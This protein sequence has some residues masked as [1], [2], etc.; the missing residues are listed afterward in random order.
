[1]G[2]P[3]GRPLPLYPTELDAFLLTSLTQNTANKPLR[4]V[5]T[6]N[7]CWLAVAFNELLQTVIVEQAAKN[8]PPG[9]PLLRLRLLDC[10]PA[11]HSKYGNNHH[12][13]T[14]PAGPDKIHRPDLISLNRHG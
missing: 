12:Q 2:F 11:S 14:H 4:T 5:I 1:V 8:L 9:G 3:D 13:S 10:N 6:A 7:V